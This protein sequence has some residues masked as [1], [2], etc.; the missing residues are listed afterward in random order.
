MNPNISDEVFSAVMHFLDHKRA[1]SAASDHT[2]KAY[3]EDVIAWLS[4][5]GQHY[6]S[7]FSASK[8][9]QISLQDMR[10]WMAHERSRKITARSLARKLSSVKSF[11]RWIAERE[12]FDATD[13]LSMRAPKFSSKLPRPIAPDDAIDVIDTAA[14]QHEEQW[15]N[16]RDSAVITLLYGCGLRISEAL[17]LTAD[18]LPLTDSL[19]ILGKGKKERIVPLLP[20]ARQAVEQ[21]ISLCPYPMRRGEALFKGKRGG[22]LNP[23]L[24]SR[25]TAAVRMQLGLPKSV[26][27]HAMRHS[28]ATHLLNAGGDLRTIQELLGHASLS[29]TQAYTAVDGARILEVYKATH[30]QA[31]S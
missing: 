21:Y 18:H 6:G 2:I 10:A 5:L 12:N 25:A 29:T 3:H 9:D 27:P 26:T 20:I 23:R 14:Q 17:G 11:T 24:I 19:R 16:A 28:F 31:K 15:M 7:S 22:A 4:F 1:L 8:I 13:I 30:P